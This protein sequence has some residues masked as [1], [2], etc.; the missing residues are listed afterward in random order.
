MPEADLL[1]WAGHALKSGSPQYALEMLQQLPSERLEDPEAAYLIGSAYEALG[2]LQEAQ[3][4]FMQ[5]RYMDGRNAR[6]H[7]QSRWRAG[8]LRSKLFP[9]IVNAHEAAHEA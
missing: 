8:L 7:V 1:R 3:E 5:S 4:A 9:S 6:L 2:R